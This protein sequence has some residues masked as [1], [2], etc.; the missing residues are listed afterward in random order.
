[1]SKF[2]PF[3]VFM[4]IIQLLYSTDTIITWKKSNL[5]P[6]VYFILGHFQYF[7]IN[8]CRVYLLHVEY[9]VYNLRAKSFPGQENL[10]FNVFSHVLQLT[11][12]FHESKIL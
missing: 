2:M 4:Q 7:R 8:S 3:I 1:M 5:I 12:L 11:F 9:V 6:K 10:T